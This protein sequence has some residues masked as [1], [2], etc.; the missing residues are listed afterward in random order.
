VD[1]RDGDSESRV[2]DERG[3]ELTSRNP[4][5]QETR[6]GCHPGEPHPEL[7]GQK[8]KRPRRG[9]SADDPLLRASP[10]R[11]MTSERPTRT[12]HSKTPTAGESGGRRPQYDEP[13]SPTDPQ[14]EPPVQPPGPPP[15]VAGHVVR[16]ITSTQDTPS[17]QADHPRDP[18]VPSHRPPKPGSVHPRAPDVR[19]RNGG[20]LALA[21]RGRAAPLNKDEAAVRRAIT[22]NRPECPSPPSNPS[23]L[24]LLLQ[25]TSY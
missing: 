9:T 13:S 20:E 16:G 2:V 23:G 10:T 1:D 12:P 22:S 14:P 11:A 24:P 3:T 5:E 7:A 8:Q 21:K 25:G 18:T 15:A 19:P 17:P 6:K 4:G